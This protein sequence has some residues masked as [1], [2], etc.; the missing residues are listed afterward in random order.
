MD[1]SEDFDEPEI[2]S[3]ELDEIYKKKDKANNLETDD[4]SDPFT[5]AE[6]MYKQLQDYCMYNGLDFFHVPPYK[7]VSN[8]M[9]LLR[10]EEKYDESN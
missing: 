5:V 2:E 1:S 3:D 6:N 8:L 9:H 7:T 10:K 4:L